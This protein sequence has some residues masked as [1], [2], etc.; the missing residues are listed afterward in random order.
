MT[1]KEAE[2]RERVNRLFREARAAYLDYAAHARQADHPG[3]VETP[4][5][6]AEWR[7]LYD[8]QQRADAAWQASGTWSRP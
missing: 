4:E 2:M 3:F 6:A 1:P 7:R 8:A 5:W